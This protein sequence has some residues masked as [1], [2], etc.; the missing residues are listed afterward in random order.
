MLRVSGL[1]IRPGIDRRPA[2][3]V[4]RRSF[5]GISL[6][7]GV[8]GA[9]RATSAQPVHKPARIGILGSSGKTADLVGPRPRGASL[10]ALLDGLRERG[11]V[12]GEHFVTE[13]RSAEGKPERF[14]GLAAELVRLQ[15]DVIVAAGPTLGA[16]KQATST[17]PVVMAVSGDPVGEGLVQSLARPGGNFTGLSSLGVEVTGKRL[18]LLK[19]IA[20]GPGPVGVLWDR[21]VLLNW[22][23]TQAVARERGWQL[24]S[25][26]IRNAGDLE[27]VFKAATEARVSALYVF[28]S[29]PLFGQARRVAELAAKSR[30]PAMYNHMRYVEEGGLMSYSVDILD[31]WRRAA[32]FVD[33]ILKGAKPADLPVEQPTK[34]DLVINLKTVKALSL[35][36]P[37][38]V[39]VRADRVIQ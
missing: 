14:P 22:Q 35:T 37:P 16:L 1:I 11:Y 18:E 7:L 20:Q 2:S 4:G 17:I 24:L 25:F 8:L 27:G 6:A 34:V 23:E 31:I 39:M 3:G 15:P 19:E 32:V 36:I 12:W 9:R 13:V 26:E 30:L 29:A 38:S 28:S 10:R 33:K 21:T 5:I